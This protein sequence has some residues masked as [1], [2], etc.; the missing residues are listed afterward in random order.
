MYVLPSPAI[1]SL[2][3]ALL[4]GM[5]AILGER[6]VGLYLYGSLVTGDFDLDVSD[7]DMLAVIES[8][9]SDDEFARLDALHGAIVDAHPSWRE[10]VEVAYLA[11]AA[12]KTFRTQRSPIAVISPGEP[13]HI[14]DAGNDWLLN[15]WVIRRGGVALWGPPPTSLIDPIGDDE[16]HAA[17]VRQVG[18]WQDWVL[19]MRSR[20][21]HAYAILTMCRAL[22]LVERGEQVSKLAAARWAQQRMPAWAALI[23]DALAWRS[24][25]DETGVDHDAS[26]DETVGFVRAVGALLGV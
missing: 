5:R 26:F 19:H 11:C 7:I 2:L 25:H 9:L 16:F 18:E 23:G 13:F 17:I 14:K 22:H 21:A 6:L 20:K 1:A 4:A 8:D 15:W 24:A 12:L 10:R 3:D